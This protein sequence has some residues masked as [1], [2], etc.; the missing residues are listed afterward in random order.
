VRAQVQVQQNQNRSCQK[1]GAE[2]VKVRRLGIRE[3]I[4]WLGERVMKGIG[5]VELGF[6]EI[7]DA[8]RRGAYVG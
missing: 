2:A 8:G 4:D 6:Y 7:E 3:L 5:L 1:F